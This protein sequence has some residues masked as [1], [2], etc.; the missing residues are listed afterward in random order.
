MG[1]RIAAAVACLRSVCV[2]IARRATGIE[3]RQLERA[4]AGCS[5]E[6]VRRKDMVES[7]AK[8]CKAVGV[9]YAF[10]AEAAALM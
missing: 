4:R 2:A 6:A 5:L 8:Q 1:A 10:E 7:I 3:A 9:R